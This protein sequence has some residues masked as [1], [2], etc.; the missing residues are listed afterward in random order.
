MIS[1]RIEPGTD[2]DTTRYMTYDGEG[3][4]LGAL[5]IREARMQYGA[6]TFDAPTRTITVERE[7]G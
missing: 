7:R 5:T 4:E 6:T 2:G 3:I 1:H